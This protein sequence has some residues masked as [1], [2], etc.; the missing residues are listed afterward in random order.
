VLLL[1]S[2]IG[3]VNARYDMEAMDFLTSRDKVLVGSEEI[4][5]DAKS[6]SALDGETRFRVVSRL[7]SLLDG[8]F[9]ALR[10]H[11]ALV[12]KSLM[13][14]RPNN[15]VLLGR[16]V[17]VKRVYGGL[18]FTKKA[19][20]KRPAEPAV[21]DIAPGRNEIA[22]L[23]LVLH[24]SEEER[25]SGPL[26]AGSDTALFDASRIGSLGVRT[27]R[28]GD[29]FTPL[30]ME[31][32]VKL[33]DFFIARKTPREARATMP[34]LVSDG[35]IAWFVGV[36]MSETHKVTPETTRV[37]RVRVERAQE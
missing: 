16:G 17:R 10:E 9:T 18:V 5:V 7:C 13:S 26:P 20:A 34:L 29:R 3:S 35:E 12:D 36:R 15:S 22:P 23:G 6:L 14:R 4:L 30:G 33:K 27:F 2:D 25:P 28:D 31:R 19:P 37:V 21:F 11:L 32:P 8:K 24:V 1:L